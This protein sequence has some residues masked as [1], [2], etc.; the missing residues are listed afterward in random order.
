MD[1]LTNTEVIAVNQDDLAQPMRPV[2]REDG[3]EIWRKPLTEHRTAVVL[4]HRNYSSAPQPPSPGPTPH[5]GM[6]DFANAVGR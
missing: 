1:T 4:F 5:T 3:L 6:N 2:L